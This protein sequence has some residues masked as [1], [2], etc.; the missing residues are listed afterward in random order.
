MTFYYQCNVNNIGLPSTQ[1]NISNTVSPVFSMPSWMVEQTSSVSY[2][3]EVIVPVYT[4]ADQAVVASQTTVS[5]AVKG[6]FPLEFQINTDQ[7]NKCEESGGWCGLNTNSGFSCFYRNQ[8]YATICNGTS[9]S[10]QP[11][12]GSGSGEN[13]GRKF[14]CK[15]REGT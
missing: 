4:A 1:C 2:R 15:Q 12:G 11:G 7:S 5:D 9:N 8:A 13:P 3:D 14:E 10:T 6:G